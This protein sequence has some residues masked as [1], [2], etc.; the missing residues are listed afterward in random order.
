MPC[1]F[2]QIS[3][4]NVVDDDINVIRKRAWRYAVF[5]AYQ[6]RCPAAEDREFINNAFCYDPDYAGSLPVGHENAFKDR[7]RMLAPDSRKI[8][9]HERP[10]PHC[11]GLRYTAVASGEDYEYATCANTC[12]VVKCEACGLIYLNPAPEQGEF[13]VIYPQE[14]KPYH[15]NAGQ[16][17]IMR[18]RDYLD[19]SKARSF[20]RL[21]PEEARILDLGCG[22]GR[23]LKIMSRA[24]PSWRLEGIDF[25]AQAVEHCRAC[26]YS[27]VAGS[28]EEADLPSNKYDLINCNQ[29]IEH[30]ADPAAALLKTHRELKPGGLINIETPSLEGWDARIFRRSFWGG[31]HFPRHL[32]FFTEDSLQMFLAARGFDVVSVEYLVSPVFWVFSLHHWWRA[33]IGRG[34]GLFSDGNP[35]A[36]ALATG[37]DIVQ[38]TVRRKTSNMRII[39]RKNG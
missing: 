27:A 31:Y 11:G 19:T 16:N 36:L 29:V 13:A 6:P 33:H 1:P 9:M 15:F 18:V 28:Y 14:Y 26:G 22:D 10:C 3:F 8:Q 20:L 24:C 21:L 35:L 4:G 34:A 30:M 32:I 38:R 5:R 7:A 17:F 12:R 23:Y 2:I 39:A 37:L 25:S